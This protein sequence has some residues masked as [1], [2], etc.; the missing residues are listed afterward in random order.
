MLWGVVVA[1]AIAV[2]VAIL[3]SQIGGGSSVA[4]LLENPS[5]LAGA[6]ATSTTSTDLTGTT[7]STPDAAT[8]TT[9]ET[10]SIESSDHT[11]IGDI[12]STADGGAD[13]WI[14]RVGVRVVSTTS[15]QGVA[16]AL[17]VGT[18]SGSALATHAATTDETGVAEFVI[19]GLTGPST[20][21]TVLDVIAEA[22][23]Y[24]PTTNETTTVTVPGPAS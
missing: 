7:L 5:L 21:F 17:V 24:E 4:T 9:P 19:T 16:G 18:W 23:P 15:P 10:T 11:R 6:A 20:R 3:L 12:T 2:P 14:A 22:A 8:S 13:N 1:A